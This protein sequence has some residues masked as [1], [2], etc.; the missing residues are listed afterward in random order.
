MI[1]SAA[2]ARRAILTTLQARLPA[3]LNG[4]ATHAAMALPPPRMWRRLPDYA[5]VAE[6][7]LPAVYVVAGT[8]DTQ[9]ID[10][11]YATDLQARVVAV[12]AGRS[13]EEADDRA[14][15]YATAIRYALLADGS[16]AG[17]AS[18]VTWQAESP[19]GDDSGDHYRAQADVTVTY[20]IHVPAHLPPGLTPGVPQTYAIDE[21][22]L[23]LRHVVGP[24]TPLPTPTGDGP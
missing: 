12:V 6:E 21:I 13:M 15:H 17:E 14:S 3:M 23:D 19:A 7:Q 2:D 8:L 4:L 11:D 20:R 5:N 9:D 1:L 24:D 10:D 18:G 22:L 16:L